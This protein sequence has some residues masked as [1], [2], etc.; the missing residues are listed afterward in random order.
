MTRKVLGRG[1]DAL[2]PV[3][4]ATEEAETSSNRVHMIALEK[5]HPN[6]R[7]PRRGFD[8]TR[9]DELSHSVREM[10]ILE[11]VIVRVAEDGGYELVAGE[12]RLRAAQKAG[13][14][15]IP[16][17]IRE[18]AGRQSLEVALIENLQREDL[19]PVDEARA[20]LR[21]T[22]EF[23][24]THAEISRDVGKDRSTISNLIRL[25]RLPDEILSNVSRGTLSTGHARVLLALEDHQEQL[26]LA[27]TM[28]REG[29]SVRKAEQYLSRKTKGTTEGQPKP[30]EGAE[31]QRRDREVERIEEALR[32]VLGTEVHLHHRGDNGSIEIVYASREELERILDLLKVQVH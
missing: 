12:R 32:Y 30:T 1:L 7:Q 13:L 3:D 22:E 27:Q 29:W 11:P 10:G 18:F 5:I 19:N 20:Y 24:R 25:L 28:I 14:R 4:P 17:L 23:G 21:L 31:E 2:I 15:E 26:T 16:A 6:P 8:E 9:L